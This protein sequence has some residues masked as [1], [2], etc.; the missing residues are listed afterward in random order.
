MIKMV[1]TCGRCDYYGTNRKCTNE[2][3]KYY[4]KVA[5]FSNVVWDCPNFKGE[6]YPWNTEKAI[7]IGYRPS[8]FTKFND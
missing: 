8:T 6:L 1:K 2:A 3:C 4:G 7:P 5:N